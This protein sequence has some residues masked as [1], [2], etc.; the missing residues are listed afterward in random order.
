MPE[1]VTEQQPDTIRSDL[2]AAVSAYEKQQAPVTEKPSAKG[3]G[4]AASE[5]VESGD[6]FAEKGEGKTER[7]RG[8]DGKFVS[9]E[10]AEKGETAEKTDGEG[11]ETTATE[12]AV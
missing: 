2:D 4:E 7:A 5:A 12:T 10:D 11:A 1:T 3:N 9:A 6:I 8:A